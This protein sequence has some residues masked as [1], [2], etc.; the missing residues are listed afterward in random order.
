M[1]LQYIDTSAL[2]AM[3]NKKDKNHSRAV[4]YFKK[5]VKGGGRF[6]L[7]KHILIEYIDG[8]TKRIDK[9]KAIE[10]LNN[11]IESKLLLIEWENKKDWTRAI[12]YF[13]KYR[14]REV[15]LTDCISFSIMERIGISD[16]FTFDSDFQMHGFEI[17]V[18]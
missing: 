7:G 3:S 18:D 9:K 8:V 11:I 17:V 10:D 5:A 12:E 2:I 15:D 13:K 14:D 4:A 16:A 1:K 6:L